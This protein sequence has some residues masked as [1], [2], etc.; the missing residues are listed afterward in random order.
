[1]ERFIYDSFLHTWKW[2]H[3]ARGGRDPTCITVR[4]MKRAGLLF[5][6]KDRQ[7]QRGSGGN[8]A[9]FREPK[10]Q[11]AKEEEAMETSVRVASE[12]YE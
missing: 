3:I 4:E 1:L 10:G 2:Q 6:K 8:P 11:E 9:F 5:K 7:R 12:I